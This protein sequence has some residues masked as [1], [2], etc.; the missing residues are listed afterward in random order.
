[1]RCP[2]C[3]VENPAG[4]RFCGGCGRAL[5]ETCP[6]CG[7]E[8]TP[9]FRFCGACGHELAQRAEPDKP[10]VSA[11]PTTER[12]RVTVVFA[13]LVGFSTLAEHLDP[14]NLNVLVTETLRELAAEVE[15]RG[16]TVENF[17]GDSLVAIFGAPQAHEDDPERAVAS[18]VA[19]RDAI[20]H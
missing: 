15:R 20:A 2:N 7:A 1:M 4:F 19:I 13:D 3:A 5:A 9:G 10:T 16:G 12:R 14:E 11:A 17:A 18:A 8:V 6:A